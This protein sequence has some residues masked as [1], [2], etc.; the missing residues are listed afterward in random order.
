MTRREF[1]A[2]VSGAAAIF[3]FVA[4]AQQASAKLP[5]IGIID[6][7]PIWN[8]FRQALRE[9]GYIEG[10]TIEYE[11]RVADGNPKRLATAAIEL[12]NIPVDLIATYGTPP[13]RAAKSATANIPIVM[14]AIGDPVRAGLVQS[15]AH[16]NGNVTGNTIISPELSSK[17]LQLVKQVIPS[18]TRVALLWNPDNASNAVILEQMRVAALALGLAFSAVEASNTKDLENV[19]ATLAQERPDA[20]LLTSDPLH[21]AHIQRIVGFLLQHRLPSM[22][23]SR[24]DA[25]AGA[26]ISYGAKFPDLFRQGA[27]FTNKILKGT[28]PSDI[29]VQTPQQFQLV[30]NMRTA[31]SLGV[32]VPSTLLAV[33]DEVIE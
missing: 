6:D 1:I 14:I 2:V 23:Q 20:V 22:C 3:P 33:A 13:S 9:L 5:R 16:P 30:I 8:P 15:I 24:E 12:S 31:K 25:T 7:G 27:F 29:P 19:L 11:Y 26:L 21:H 28:K 17:R 4:F 18:A 32:R 10:K